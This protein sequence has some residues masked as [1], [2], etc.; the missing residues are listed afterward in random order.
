MLN[1]KVF[2][3]KFKGHDTFSVWPVDASGDKVGQYPLFS[4]GGRKA[5]AVLR[6]LE[7]FKTFGEKNDEVLVKELE[8]LSK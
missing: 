3:E 2:I 4:V 8:K 5:A 7:E 6:H 1:T